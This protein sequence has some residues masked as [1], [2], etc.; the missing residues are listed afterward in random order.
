M[1]RTG[2]V[3]VV[4]VGLLSACGHTP[5]ERVLSGALIGTAVG[6]AVG[7]ASNQGHHD[8]YYES[9]RHYREKRRGHRHK[10]RHYD[11]DDY[12]DDHYYD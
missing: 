11:W 7:L 5:E 1:L 10:R 2:A 9:D 4:I 12:D 8:D 6:A 3:A